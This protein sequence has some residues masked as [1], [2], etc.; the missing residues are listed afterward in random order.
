MKF[1]RDNFYD[2]LSD[3]GDGDVLPFPVYEDIDAVG[4]VG[5]D[6]DKCSAAVDYDVIEE[7]P[8]ITEVIEEYPVID[9][10]PD[11]AVFELEH[12]EPPPRPGV[13]VE[14]PAVTPLP[15]PG[16]DGV[17]TLGPELPT[18]VT[19]TPSPEPAR[20]VT[21]YPYYPVTPQPTGLTPYPDHQPEYGSHAKPAYGSHHS[22]HSGNNSPQ[23]GYSRPQSGHH[24][25]Q[26]GYSRPHSGYSRLHSGYNRPHSSYKTPQPSYNSPKPS[27]HSP[28]PKPS[29]N[30]PQSGY[31]SPE[32]SYNSPTPRP[33][34]GAPSSKP[35][36]NAPS[37]RPSYNS[38]SPRP[39]Y[40]S[41][42]PK[43]S[44]DSPTPRPSYNTPTPKPSYHAP[45][46]G[47]NSPKP[48]YNAPTPK[49]SYNTPQPGYNSPK[50]GYHTPK[51]SY[52]YS[53]PKPN[54]STAKPSYS[55]PKP[56]YNSPKPAYNTPKPSYGT[57]KPA[58]GH[59]DASEDGNYDFSYNVVDPKEGLDFGA[60][61]VKDDAGRTFGEYHVALP[62]GRRQTVTYSVVG[63]SGFVADV[64]YDGEAK[65]D[66]YGPSGSHTGY[67]APQHANPQA[68][69]GVP[70][71]PTQDVYQ[72]GHAIPEAPV[73]PVQAVFP[74]YGL[75][76]PEQATGFV[77]PVVYDEYIL[78]EGPP[79][80]GD[81]VIYDY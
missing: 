57:P 18:A 29:Y 79:L 42:T 50:P 47:Y 34:Y 13:V 51:P 14:L 28:T 23:S 32:P 33:S 5:A 81:G 2:L 22:H 16:S 35:S 80:N 72:P 59:D 19:V 44:Y 70:A 3:S 43:P 25:P 31:N 62:D 76:V 12:V 26:S 52:G 77:E 40:N 64:N 8:D 53:T 6:C 68:D 30:A 49:P 78:F 55:S 21:E 48:S 67:A 65:V 45:Q 1:I 58:Y 20:P 46:P 27:Y 36:Y 66:S 9:E 69:Y 11:Y 39:S 17:D 71:Q 60:S 61:E 7:Y 54:Y 41:P 4:T 73:A 38:P 63:D 74:D 37:P 75:G 15:F 24:N 56:S 10:F